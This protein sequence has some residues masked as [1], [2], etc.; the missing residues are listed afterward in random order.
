MNGRPDLDVTVWDA[1]AEVAV[2]VFIRRH[3]ASSAP[4]D[5]AAFAE[6]LRSWSDR[7]LDHGQAHLVE[8]AAVGVVALTLV[9]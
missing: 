3:L 5:D 9:Q 8:L 7:L 6:D 1:Q 4:P 2:G